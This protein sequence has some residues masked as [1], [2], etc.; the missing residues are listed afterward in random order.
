[1]ELNLAQLVKKLCN[2]NCFRLRLKRVRNKL[3]ILLKSNC[4]LF[5][6]YYTETESCVYIEAANGQ[7]RTN[8]HS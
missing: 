4:D 5:H 8:Q 6:P 7:S 2:E 3:A 1:M